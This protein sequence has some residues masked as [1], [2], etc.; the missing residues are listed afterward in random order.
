[1]G[2]VRDLQCVVQ[3]HPEPVRLHPRS[4]AV[5][6]LRPQWLGGPGGHRAGRFHRHG[7]GAAHRQAQREVRHSVPGDGAG[8]HGGTRREF[9]GGGTRHRRD[10]LVRRADLFRLDRGG[11]VA[12]DTARQRATGRHAARPDRHRLGRL[13]DRL[14]VSGGAV[15]PWRRLGNALSQLGRPAGL[16]GDDR[17]D[18]RHLVSGRPEPAWRPRR[19]LQRQRRAR[20]RTDRRVRRGGRHHGRL[21]RRRGDQL[22]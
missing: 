22:R 12:A 19:H 5:H 3:R 4:H 2:L 20:R 6:Q 11:P 21:L 9:P 10:L 1:M 16:P 7:S 13:R 8:E 18:D 17:T 15:R 14:R